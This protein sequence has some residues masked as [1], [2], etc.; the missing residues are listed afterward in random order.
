MKANMLKRLTDRIYYIPNDSKT[1]RP[2]LGLICGDKYSLVVDAG[3]SP[4]HANEFW[5]MYLN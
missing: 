3:N 5:Q 2:V 4:T 1:D